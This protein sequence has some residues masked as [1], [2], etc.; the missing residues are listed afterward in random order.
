MRRFIRHPVNIPIEV[1]VTGHL[2]LDATSISSDL[3]AGG[4]AFHSKHNI[5]PGTLVC[6]KIPY[7]QPAFETNAKVIWCRKRLEDNELGVE[8]LTL[9]DAFKVRMVEQVCYIED[10]KHSIKRDEGRNLTVQEAAG[11]W[12]SKYAADFP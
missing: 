11:E 7:V 4:L 3:A 8:F 6:I 10:Y 2:P 1:T 12:I 5:E 9:D